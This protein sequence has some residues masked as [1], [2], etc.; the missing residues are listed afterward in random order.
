[1]TVNGFSLK[2][3][4]GWAQAVI[5]PKVDLGLAFSAS[6][7]FLTFCTTSGGRR[8]CRRVKLFRPANLFSR[9]NGIR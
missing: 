4:M 5:W 3:L 8:R 9:S 7:A 6:L 1:M 2:A